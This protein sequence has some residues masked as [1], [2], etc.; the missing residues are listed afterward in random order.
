MLLTVDIATW[1]PIWNLSAIA[2]TDVYKLN[3]M[4][5]Y[6]ANWT[7]FEIELKKGLTYIG[8]DKLGV[9]LMTRDGE[10]LSQWLPQA[11]VLQRFDAL[12]KAGVTEVDIW[13]TPL[14]EFWYPII[15]QWEKD[16]STSSLDRH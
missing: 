16:S 8:L 7:L 2:A 15:Q 1:N 10:N 6:T 9:G 5:T 11:D 12:T 14:P 3:Y 4:E 13:D